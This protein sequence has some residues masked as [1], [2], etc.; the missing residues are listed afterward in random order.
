MS[1]QIKCECFLSKDHFKISKKKMKATE[2]TLL[3]FR[4]CARI[5]GNAVSLQSF[6][7]AMTYLIRKHH[8]S[9]KA[10]SDYM[11]YNHHGLSIQIYISS[12][13]YQTT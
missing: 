9:V 3:S 2:F 10:F 4:Y 5:T 7:L 6:L 13:S 8:S 11:F 12:L 1:K